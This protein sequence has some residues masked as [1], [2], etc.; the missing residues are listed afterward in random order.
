MEVTSINK[1]KELSKG[2][3]VKLIGFNEE[4]FIVRLRRPSLLNMVSNNKIPNELLIAAHTLFF[5]AKT[6]KDSINMEE[7]NELYRLIA[8]ESLVEPTLEQIE[9]AGLELTDQQLIEIFHYTQLGVTALKSFRDEQESIKNSTNQ[10]K[11]QSKT[12]RDNRYR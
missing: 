8:K 12:K 4:P 3:I 11:I 9:D 7:S 6:P 1:L 2:E 10:Q 5:G